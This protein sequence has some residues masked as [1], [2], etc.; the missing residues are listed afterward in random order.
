[1]P[2][3]DKAGIG[4]I[5][6]LWLE[7]RARLHR[8]IELL[9]ADRSSR[10][11]WRDAQ[12]L[13]DLGDLTAD[14]L[15]GK[16]LSHPI[17]WPRRGPDAETQALT[18]VLARANRAGLVTDASQPGVAGETGPSGETWRQRAAVQ[19]WMAP[20]Q[21]CDLE[22]AALSEGFRVVRHTTLRRRLDS[23]SSE[24]ID[25]T[26]KGDDVVTGFGQQPYVHDL[27][28]WL[29]RCGRGAIEGLL[30]AHLVAVASSEYG[31]DDRVWDLLDSWS[32]RQ[33]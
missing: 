16:V 21:A 30:G 1:M 20:E 28:H 19:G 27:R 14:W 12:S 26:M 8:E 23:P 31:H 4:M 7:G 9:R 29:S 22:C 15:E 10:G 2:G 5:R 25:V 13:R 17:C 3:C 32:R 24:W 6:A 18:P 11:R 33:E